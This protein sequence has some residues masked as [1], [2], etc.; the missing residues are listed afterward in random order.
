[1][2]RFLALVQELRSTEVRVYT[3]RDWPLH[4]GVYQPDGEALAAWL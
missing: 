1:M 2:R 4:A 3:A